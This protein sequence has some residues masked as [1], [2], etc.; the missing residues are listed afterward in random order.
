M[1]GEGGAAPEGP[2]D[3]FSM[4]DAAPSMPDDDS[5]SDGSAEPDTPEPDAGDTADKP[6]APPVLTFGIR[7]DRVSAPTDS[8]PDPEAGSAAPE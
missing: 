2:D 4:P 1:R 6:D 8:G 7:P 3:E 5:G